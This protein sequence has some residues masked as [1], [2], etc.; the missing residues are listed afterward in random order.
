MTAGQVT[1]EGTWWTMMA[2][3]SQVPTL[4]RWN[5]GVDAPTLVFQIF[6]QASGRLGEE[7]GVHFVPLFRACQSASPLPL[8]RVAQPW[9]SPSCRPPG[10]V[11]KLY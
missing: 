9:S 1:T 8:P 4:P 11:E 3:Q 2:K 6:T 10:E 7:P 5:V